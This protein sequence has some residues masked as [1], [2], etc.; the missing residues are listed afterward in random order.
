MTNTYLGQRYPLS[1]DDL[2]RMRVLDVETGKT[3]KADSLIGANQYGEIGHQ[4]ALLTP[5]LWRQGEGE[6]PVRLTQAIILAEL[7]HPLGR[8]RT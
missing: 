6:K 2:V 4:I 5:A 8:R 7:F 3:L 1:R